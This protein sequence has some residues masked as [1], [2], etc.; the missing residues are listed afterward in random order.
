MGTAIKHNPVPDRVKLSFVILTLNQ[1]HEHQS[2]QM[3]K[4]SLSCSGTEA[5]LT[6]QQYNCYNCTMK[7]SVMSIFYLSEMEMMTN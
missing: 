2:A 7:I 4:T 6:P 1:Y 5:V 3:S